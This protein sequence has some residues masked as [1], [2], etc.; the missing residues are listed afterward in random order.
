MA[1]IKVIEESDAGG[2]AKEAFAR[3]ARE[4]GKLSNIMKVQGLNA[5][6][7]LKH[8]ELYVTLMFGASPLSRPERELIG[9]VV[10]AANGCAYCARHHGTALNFY[11]KDD[12]R[13]AA[14][15]RD[16]RNAEL[17]A[18]ER[19]LAAYAEKL[20]REPAE[21]AAQDAAALRDHGFSDREILDANMITAYFNFANRIAAGL[22][23]EFTAAE[24]AGYKA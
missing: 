1:W 9:V 17:S 16:W 18:R 5:A 10:S 12:E 13:V 2:P 8:L 20:T 11:W 19:A 22:G 3:V 24:A 7:M 15:A 23:V 6:A 14:A 4:R 21:M